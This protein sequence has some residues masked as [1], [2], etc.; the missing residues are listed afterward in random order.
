MREWKFS[1]ADTSFGSPVGDVEKKS[2]S[3][4]AEHVAPPTPIH[5]WGAPFWRVS[6]IDELFQD[7]FRRIPM[8]QPGFNWHIHFFKPWKD[9]WS[10]GTKQ[11]LHQQHAMVNGPAVFTHDVWMIC[12]E[13][14]PCNYMCW[15]LNSHCFPMV[16][17]GW[18]IPIVGV[19]IPSLSQCPTLI[20]TFGDFIYL[21]GKIQFKL[22]FRG[23]LAE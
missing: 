3:R 7:V 14:I 20:L 12:W 10:P 15:G 22:L 9:S 19:Y 13:R 17:D 5:F 6:G 1:P 21:I 11:Q 18:C 4:V 8:N 16:E 23:P 2:L